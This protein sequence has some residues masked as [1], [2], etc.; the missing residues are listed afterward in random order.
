MSGLFTSE[1]WVRDVP[2]AVRSALL[3]R[4][5]LVDLAP[6]AQI[7]KAGDPP[8]AMFQVDYGYL[9]L[10]GLHP[11][12]RQFLI[13][14]YGPGNLFGETPLVGDRP[15]S[16]STVA[17]TPA[18]VRRLSRD[19]FWDLYAAH[20]EIPEALCRKFARNITRGFAQRELRATHRLRGQIAAMLADIATTCGR[21]EPGGGASF[22]LPITQIDI[23]EHL[24]A[25]R[26]AVQREVSS[27]KAAGL[28]ERRDGRWHVLDV[29]ALRRI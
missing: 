17:M 20:P 3:A 27:L 25:T 28:V 13:M 21:V 9:R 6:G 11:D 22:A 19:A 18:R 10:L 7:K 29:Q 4:T 23:A 24:E 2:D 15:Y 16:H 5:T 8:D 14:L 1:N 26:Q 12:G